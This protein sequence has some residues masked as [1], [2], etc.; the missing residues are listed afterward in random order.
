ML[1]KSLKI[2]GGIISVVMGIILSII[3]NF[4]SIAQKH[5]Y[6]IGKKL[7]LN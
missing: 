4:L 3:S 6:I 7:K 2:N 5:K 1:I